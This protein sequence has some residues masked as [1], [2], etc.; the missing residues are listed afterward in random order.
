MNDNSNA[1]SG[2]SFL[3]NM[4]KAGLANRDK[5]DR[6]QTLKEDLMKPSSE[7]VEESLP[8]IEQISQIQNLQAQQV[9]KVQTEEPQA[10]PRKTLKTSPKA[11]VG[12]IQ[13]N[14]ESSRPPMQFKPRIAKIKV[15]G[16]GGAGCNAIERMIEGSPSNIEFIAMNTD[17]Q[18]L[19]QLDVDT[20]ILLGE[21]VTKNRGAGSKPDVGRK[22]AEQNID[23]IKKCVSGADLV[24]IAAGMGR[25]TGTGV[26]PIVA[27]IAKKS[28][29]LTIAIVTKPFGFEGIKM[30]GIA[31]EGIA[32]LS[33]KVD[34]IIT[35][36]NDKL[37][38]IYK[39]I[40]FLEAFRRVDEI[41][42]YGVRGIAEVLSGTGV[43]NVDFADVQ[44]I[45]QNGG[46]SQV[47]IGIG[48]GPDRAVLAAQNAIYSPLLET[49]IDGSKSIL[50]NITGDSNITL[51][52]VRTAADIIVNAADPNARIVFGSVIDDSI[53]D[54]A[55]AIT[56]IATG[57]MGEG[58]IQ[59]NNSSDDDYS[60]SESS[61]GDYQ[62]PA[63]I[64]SQSFRDSMDTN[65]KK[66]MSSA[67][68]S[69]S[70]N[71]NISDDDDLPVFRF[72]KNK[73]N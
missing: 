26:A 63:S 28:G 11:P 17:A 71:N 55:M 18:S 22:A 25:G 13:K 32:E 62:Q 50:F 33:D 68:Q 4:V 58:D 3:A 49:S 16:I 12:Q 21:K 69:N 43:I 31:K 40:T 27:D 67:M 59:D 61:Y 2:G 34:T 46:A 65:N 64:F 35:I 56:V 44:S 57:L 9:Q 10:Q 29:A 5:D 30:M 19:D 8:D 72:R 14:P 39:D 37:I 42:K 15:I 20:K 41:L 66:G 38:S 1:K 51:H 73:G 60:S 36:P 23:E 48:R 53:T 7:E 6:R 54:G 24:F 52:E 70:Y 47:G 45:L